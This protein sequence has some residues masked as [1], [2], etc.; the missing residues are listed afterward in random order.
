LKKKIKHA[1]EIT[2]NNQ[3]L[4]L[5]IAWNYGGRDEIVLALE[6]IMAE[7]VDPSKVTEQTIS[8]HLMTAG[9]PDPDL[10]IRTSGEI[11]TS[12]FMIWTGCLFR[13][14]FHTRTLAGF[15]SQ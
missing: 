15:R 1:I 6:K 11:R 13:I 10:V 8:E 4:I 9:L 14:V 7:G 3:K 5:C 12:N 2:R